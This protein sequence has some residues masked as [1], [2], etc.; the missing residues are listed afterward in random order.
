M[1]ADAPMPAL[2]DALRS[3]GLR[4]TNQRRQVLK[5]VE[6][7]RHATADQVCARVQDEAPDLSLSTVYR[8][9]ELFEQL[10]LVTHAHLEHGAPTYHAVSGHEHLHLVCRGCGSVTE[11]SAETGR[12]FAAQ[13]AEEHGFRSDIRHLA[14]HGICVRCQAAGITDAPPRKQE[15]TR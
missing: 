3:R 11:A 2:D 5:A 15:A 14:V 1:S 6:E 4:V 12:R 9:L 7:L 10:G 8:T 13:L